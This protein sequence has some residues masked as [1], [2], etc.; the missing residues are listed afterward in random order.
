[1]INREQQDRQIQRE[2]EQKRTPPPRRRCV[3]S[4]H[5]TEPGPFRVCRRCGGE[6]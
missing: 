6:Y 2:L 5:K 3:E 4:D 1:M